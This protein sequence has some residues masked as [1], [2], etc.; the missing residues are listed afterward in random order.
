M[1]RN[2]PRA[3]TRGAGATAYGP[4]ELV[5]PLRLAE[6]EFLQVLL[7]R[8][9]LE[10]HGRGTRLSVDFDDDT[11]AISLRQAKTAIRLA[12]RDFARRAQRYQDELDAFLLRRAG[13]RYEFRDPSFR[14]R[15]VSGGSLPVIRMGSREYYCLFYRDVPPI[16]WNIANGGSDSR[17]ELLDP[18]LIVERELREELIVVDLRHR[19]RYAFAADV[20][21]P[22]EHTAFMAARRLWDKRARTLDVSRFEEWQIPLKWIDGPDTLHV[23]QARGRPHVVERCFLNV[24][25]EDFGIEID[26]IAKMKVGDDVILCDGELIGDRLVNAVV[27]L[28]EVQRFDASFAGGA[29][30]FVPDFFFYD[31]TRYESHHLSE[32]ISR[33]IAELGPWRSSEEAAAYR[34]LADRFDLCPVTRRIVARYLSMEQQ[35]TVELRSHGTSVSP[36]SGRWD[37]FISFAS[38][39][40]A[41]AR[42]VYERLRRTSSGRVFFSEET[43]RHSEFGRIID[44]ALESASCLVAVGTSAQHLQKP[45]VDYEWRSFHQDILSGRKP[46]ATLCAFVSDVQDEDLPRPLLFR[47]RI[48]CGGGQSIRTSLTKLARFLGEWHGLGDR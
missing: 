40:V 4:P 7:D 9:T 10:R 42:K 30:E 48:R 6:S 20:G 14:F 22:L 18:L 46:D 21:K 5:Q 26:R 2:G 29:T 15:Y 12:T 19:R 34:R 35:S 28:F 25:A 16:G 3:R 23:R 17:Q 43:L 44:Q 32:K 38:E 11:P 8:F 36:S 39:D 41:L 27:G 33:C 47:E 31:G 24:N 37:I 13:R 45:W 1:R